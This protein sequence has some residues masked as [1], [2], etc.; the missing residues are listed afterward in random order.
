MKVFHGKDNGS[1][2]LIKTMNSF[3]PGSRPYWLFYEIRKL[4]DLIGFSV[5][6]GEPLDL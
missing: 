6:L 1:R 4:S 2:S 5:T 3:I